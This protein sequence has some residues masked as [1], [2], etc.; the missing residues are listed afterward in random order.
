MKMKNKLYLFAVFI[1]VLLSINVTVYANDELPLIPQGDLPIELKAFCD[2]MD[3]NFLLKDMSSNNEVLDY[4]LY[5]LIKSGDI[6][7][8]TEINVYV[9]SVGKR[10]ADKTKNLDKDLHFY[11]VRNSNLEA[12][13]SRQGFVFVNMGLLAH[14]DNEAQLAFVLAREI[15]NFQYERYDRDIDLKVENRKPPT[16]LI[17]DMH[18]FYSHFAGGQMLADEG[19]FQGAYTKLGYSPLEATE[20]VKNQLFSFLPF[21][22]S[23]IDTN[24]F[25]DDYFHAYYTSKLNPDLSNPKVYDL[26]MKQSESVLIQRYYNMIEV[27]EVP[28][29]DK[30]ILFIVSKSSFSEMIELVHVE[31]CQLYIEQKQFLKAYYTAYQLLPETAHSEYLNEIQAYALYAY[32]YKRSGVKKLKSTKAKKELE[33]FLLNSEFGIFTQSLDSMDNEVSVALATRKVAQMYIQNPENTHYRL[34]AIKCLEIFNERFVVKPNFF[35]KNIKEDSLYASVKTDADIEALSKL[36]K[37]RY[38]KAE[39]LNDLRVKKPYYSCF[40][41][42]FQN[43]NFSDL[44]SHVFYKTGLK[45]KAPEKIAKPHSGK[46]PKSWKKDSLVLVHSNYFFIDGKKVDY[47]KSFA[48]RKELEERINKNATG[49]GFVCLDGNSN[50]KA[51]IMAYRYFNELIRLKMSKDNDFVLANYRYLQG[52]KKEKGIG[53]YS[54]SKIANIEKVRKVDVDYYDFILPFTYAALVY[55][56]IVPD[57]LIILQTSTVNIDDLPNRLVLNSKVDGQKSKSV[58]ENLLYRNFWTFRRDIH[59][60]EGAK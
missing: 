10:L 25:S 45:A 60:T 49:N 53:S 39:K 9:A 40:I 19:A 11:V 50:P 22:N 27:M 52:L 38:R 59:K 28:D 6:L 8:G 35:V 48:L 43:E 13:T 32:A 51:N 4:Y 2:D 55:D 5:R 17:D 54:M 14:L 37:I 15:D 58:I 57:Q 36:D 42:L 44:Y 21:V 20:L 3:A 33:P 41:D 1:V 16:L 30:E 26:K 29:E 31:M 46:H 47:K 12:Y 24:H 34:M 56:L 18:K 23:L 7:Y